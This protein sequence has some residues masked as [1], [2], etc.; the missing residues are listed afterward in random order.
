MRCTT[1]GRQCENPIN[2]FGWPDASAPSGFQAAFEVSLSL[3]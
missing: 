2:H 3:S 1:V